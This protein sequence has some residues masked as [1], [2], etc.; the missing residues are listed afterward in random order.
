GATGLV[1]K[2]T[3]TLSNLNHTFPH[4]LNVLLVA[5]TGA[6]TL[7][8]SDAANGSSV[9]SADVTFDDAAPAPLPDFGQI[10][11]GTWHPS[12]YDPAAQFSSPAPAGPYGGALALFNG[13]D[14]NGT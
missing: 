7:L 10:S 12:P 6:R 5:P 9:S 2:M 4:D 3:V 8:M 13:T 1:G 11:S 14:P